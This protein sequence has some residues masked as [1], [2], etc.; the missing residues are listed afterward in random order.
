MYY[1]GKNGYR[2]SR[3]GALVYM[4]RVCV[5]FPPRRRASV[6]LFRRERALDVL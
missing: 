2:L 6:L 3:Y 5:Y 4:V 1:Y